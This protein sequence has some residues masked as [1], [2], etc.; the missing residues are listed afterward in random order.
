M[1][2]ADGIF[3][4]PDLLTPDECQE[5]IAFTEAKGYEAAPI[6]TVSGFVMRPDIRN[7]TRVIVDDTERAEDLWR[8]ARDHIPG[9]LRGRQ[10]VGLNERFRFY[11]Y[12]P[13]ERFDGAYRRENGEESLLT[14]MVY[15]SEGF[16]GGDTVFPD[17]AVTPR[18]GMALIF[19]HQILHEGAAVISGRKY[20][21]RSDV[22]YGRFGQIRG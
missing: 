9:I 19:E 18:L 7:N 12:D 17:A 16:T 5:Y 15:L 10:A 22:M 1:E 2:I 11:R 8:R 6:T 3:T 13:G 20:V 4:V 21:L 14:F